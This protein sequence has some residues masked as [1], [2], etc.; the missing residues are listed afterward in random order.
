MTL[1]LGKVFLLC[2]IG[3]IMVNV[4]HLFDPPYWDAVTGVYRQGAWLADHGFNYS[5]LMQAPTYDFGGPRVHPLYAF[6]ALF[7]LLS[8]LLAPAGVF[9]VLHLISLASAALALAL[10][11]WI[12]RT[13]QA[14]FALSWTLVAA[15]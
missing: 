1:N 5:L 12:L 2:F 13:E 3:L 15:S 10:F 6:A 11:Y 14:A 7:A 8:K 4:P 9:F